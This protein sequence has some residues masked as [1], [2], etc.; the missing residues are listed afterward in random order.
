M[1]PPSPVRLTIVVADGRRWWGQCRSP[2]SPRIKAQRSVLV[3]AREPRTVNSRW[4]HSKIAAI[5]R[6][7]PTK[8]Y[9]AATVR[10]PFR[11]VRA[12][13]LGAS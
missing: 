13:P 4:G 5:L 1:M 8:R 12:K 3:R 2:R 11:V 10:Q 7:S 9:A 6:V